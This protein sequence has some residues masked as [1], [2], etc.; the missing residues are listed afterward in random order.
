MNKL[1][2]KFQQ[3]VIVNL[4]NIRCHLN[5]KITLVFTVLYFLIGMNALSASPLEHDEDVI[6]FPVSASITPNGRWKIPLHHWV[7]ELKEDS[8]LGKLSQ[9]VIAESLELAGLSNDDTHSTVFKQRIKWFLT[10]NKGWKKLSV[11]LSKINPNDHIAL[12]KTTFNGHAYTDIYLATKKELRTRSWIEVNIDSKSK[13]KR[14]FKGE[15][16]LI[17]A[18]GLSVIS[19]IDDTIKV[20]EVLDKQK[21]LKNT[22]VAPYQVVKGMPELY[23]HLKERG[24]YFHYVSA[25]PWQLYPSLQPFM[26]AHYPKGTLMFRH[27]RLKDTS[28]IEFLG[29]SKDYKI[30][31]IRAIIKRYPKHRFILIGDSGE[32]DAEIYATIYQQFPKNIQS[33][34]IRNVDGSNATKKSLKI[35]FK[36]IPEE[37]W[38]VF[39]LPKTVSFAY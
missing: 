16:Q 32:H 24:A 5:K 37:K 35:V 12:N 7:Y 9:K 38:Y 11:S 18:N 14:Q 29:S 1:S 21:L 10:D 23:Q 34:W 2:T 3:I 20:S 30:K 28:F 17:P 13:H 15:V 19:D 22:F 6:I 8:L 4:M 31:K 25:S 33:I 26:Q 27:F 39:L 36:D